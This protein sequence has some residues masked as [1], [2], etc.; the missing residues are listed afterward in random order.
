MGHHVDVHP[1]LESR[2]RRFPERCAVS[3]VDKL[4]HGIPV[5]DHKAV[6]APLP[7]KDI[8]KGVPVCRAGNAADVVERAHKR[9]RARLQTH[10][11]RIKI[12]VPER[13]TRY[14]GVDIVTSGLGRAISHIVLKACGNCVEGVQSGALI[15]PYRGCTIDAVQIR[16]FPVA[17]CNAAPAG[18]TRHVNHG[19]ESPVDAAPAGL[20]GRMGA[21]PLH[22]SGIPGAGL[23]QRNL[24]K[25]L[26][27]VDV[28]IAEK[29]R[30]AQPGLLHGPFL[31]GVAKGWILCEINKGANFGRYVEH[32][33]P[34]IVHIVIPADGILVQLHHLLPQ[35]HPGKKVLHSKLF[36]GRCI[37]IACRCLSRIVLSHY[38]PGLFLPALVRQQALPVEPAL[39]HRM[40]PVGAQEVEKH[41][42]RHP[43]K[44]GNIAEH[45]KIVP[46]ERRLVILAP[47][48][49][50][51]GISRPSGKGLAAEL[52]YDKGLV[53][54]YVPA[55]LRGGFRP[56]RIPAHV[57]VYA[58]N[59][60]L[61]GKVVLHPELV[62]LWNIIG[63]IEGRCK[64]P[65][66]VQ[67][68]SVVQQAAQEGVALRCGTG[69]VGNAPKAYRAAVPVTGYHL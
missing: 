28:V 69:F 29:Y 11:V 60:Q 5:G 4:L 9:N 46:V 52:A 48:A 62:G 41:P 24:V 27:P 39:V 16:V 26:E 42:W 56:R 40:L 59:V 33:L 19:R 1:G 55:K 22:K 12:G 30:N 8:R 36:R 61:P 31:H 38:I 68:P 63:H 21:H 64:E 7:A 65:G 15:A 35:R 44:V 25:G 20:T 49:G 10:L 14:F 54:K 57:F 45:R 18:V 3:L 17:F 53:R 67:S 66:G 6:E 34:Y 43:R 37:L 47:G 2:C 32:R 58:D 13:R 51:V 23:P 50:H